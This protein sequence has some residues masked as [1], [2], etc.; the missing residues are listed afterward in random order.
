MEAVVLLEYVGA[1]VAITGSVLNNLVNHKYKRVAAYVFVVSN[2][3]L[4]IRAVMTGNPGIATMHA[5]FIGILMY[6]HIP[7]GDEL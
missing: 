2:T 5:T 7:K 3:T 1:A 4:G 6:Q